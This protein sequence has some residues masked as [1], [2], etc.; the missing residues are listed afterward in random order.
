MDYINNGEYYLAARYLDETLDTVTINRNWY[1]NKEDI[2]QTGIDVAAVDLITTRFNNEAELKQ[3]MLEKGYIKSKDVDLYV[4]HKSKYHN[5]EYL[6]EYELI[7]NES[8]RTELITSL[9]KKRLTNQK[10]NMF[11]INNTLNKFINKAYYTDSFY[12]LVTCHW[13]KIDSEFKN[14]LMAMRKEKEQLQISPTE[15]KPKPKFSIKYKLQGRLTSYTN[16][17]NIIA[18]WNLYD[19]LVK[20]Y[21]TTYPNCTESELSKGIIKLY[22]EK[23]NIKDGRKEFEEELREMADKN[24]VKGQITMDMY[25][26]DLNNSD[27]TAKT[28]VQ[29]YNEMMQQM[30]EDATTLRNSPFDDKELQQM[31]TKFGDRYLTQHIPKEILRTASLEDKYRLGLMDYVDYK[32]EKRVQNG[33][34]YS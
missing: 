29:E 14:E 31:A 13:V 27:T 7:Y 17:R 16:F 6:N 28:P 32:N 25:S 15:K 24:N 22:M 9:A 2:K 8:D 33:K 1:F 26:N 10:I 3:R 30:Y 12:N 11:D 21:K 20:Q 5:K 23:L 19:D 4:V 34:R 18:T